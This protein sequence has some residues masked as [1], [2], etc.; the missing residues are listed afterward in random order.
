MALRGRSPDS[1]NIVRERLFE[2]QLTACSRNHFLR[3]AG[4]DELKSVAKGVSLA[5]QRMH[6]DRAQR[7]LQ[8]Q[9]NDFPQ[10][11][12]NPQHGGD[13]RFA[14]VN[15]VPANHGHVAR[16]NTDFRFQPVTSVTAGF[17][18]FLSISRSEL[19]AE[20]HFVSMAL[21]QHVKIRLAKAGA[22]RPFYSL[23]AGEP[24]D[25]SRFPHAVNCAACRA[26]RAKA[27]SC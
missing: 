24:R 20:S 9:P 2:S 17:H 25:F 10:R 13:S 15:R 18:G 5:H 22:K 4:L 8:F 27:L 16:I 1:Q 3:R 19:A 11:N 14:D 23:S 12:F 6:F 26:A 21:C 7:E